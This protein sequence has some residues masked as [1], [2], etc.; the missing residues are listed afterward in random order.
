MKPAFCGAQAKHQA[1]NRH[2]LLRVLAKHSEGIPLA[3]L[4]EAYPAAAADI[5]AAHKEGK[6]YRLYNPDLDPGRNGTAGWMLYHR[7]TA[8]Y[9][10][11]N[12]W[13]HVEVYQSAPV[14]EPCDLAES[15]VKLWNLQACIIPPC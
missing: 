14:R 8:L 10:L 3:E 11:G 5:T 15:P 9:P 2:Q 4:Q 6:L 7:C 13:V 1:K 12:V